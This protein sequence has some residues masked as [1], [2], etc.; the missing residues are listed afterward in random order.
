MCCSLGVGFISSSVA[1]TAPRLQR[2]YLP[3]KS[4]VSQSALD[5]FTQLDELRI[6]GNTAFHNVDFCAATLRILHANY[7]GNLADAGLGQATKLEVLHIGDCKAV[8]SVSAFAH[9]LLEL[10]ASES[11]G[12]DSAALSQCFRLQVLDA[13]ENHKIDPLLADCES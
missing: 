9:C 4:T 12:I 10:R 1:E 8:T 13:T 3:W 2:L 7:C 5:H 6:S 11:C